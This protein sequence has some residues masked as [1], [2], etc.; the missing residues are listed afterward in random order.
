MVGRVAKAGKKE[1]DGMFGKEEKIVKSKIGMFSEVKNLLVDA[2]IAVATGTESDKAR[3]KKY[4]K[5][6]NKEFKGR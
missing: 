5:T 6:F 4:E 2:Y 1:L 3:F